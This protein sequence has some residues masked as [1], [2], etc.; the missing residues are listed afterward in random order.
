MNQR[1]QIPGFPDYSFNELGELFKNGEPKKVSYKRRGR[2]KSSPQVIIRLHGKCYNFGLAKLIADEFIPNPH[3]YQYIIF[4]DGNSHNCQKQNIA[5]VDSEVYMYYCTR[6]KRKPKIINERTFAIENCT[7]FNLRNY[8]L[9]L[10]GE[11]LH[12]AWKK[13]ED[14]FSKFKFWRAVAGEAYIKFIE[15]AKRFSIWSK[16]EGIVW[17]IAKGER[18]NLE[19]TISPYWPIDRLIQVD[20]SLRVIGQDIKDNH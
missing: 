8:Y 4:K 12:E 14:D 19:K 18:V 2:R 15:R 20:E 5:W 9:T 6:G 11:W 17:F 13:V 16:P 10:D 7:D 3:D 1:V